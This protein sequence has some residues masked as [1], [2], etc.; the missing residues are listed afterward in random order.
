MGEDL[1]DLK[2]AHQRAGT[3]VVAAA[4]SRAPRRS[5]T[6]AGSGRASRAAARVTVLFGSARVPYAGPIHWGWSSR[7]IEPHPFVAEAAQ[8][9]EPDWL[10]V[11]EAGVEDALDRLSGRIY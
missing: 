6:L 2:D 9:T 8:E 5:G 1:S 7:G 11:F 10:G 3:I 4:S